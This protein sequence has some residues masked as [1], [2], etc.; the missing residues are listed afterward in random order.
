M[1]LGRPIK[2]LCRKLQSAVFWVVKGQRGRRGGGG[3]SFLWQEFPP[4]VSTNSQGG[5]KC[6]LPPP[7]V[8]PAWSLMEFLIRIMKALHPF[9]Y[10]RA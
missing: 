6:P 8:G 10:N 9:S 2:T 4:L 5:G 7:D 3:N 1:I